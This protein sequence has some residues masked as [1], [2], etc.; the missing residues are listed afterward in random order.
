MTKATNGT[1]SVNNKRD[2][3][4]KYTASRIVRGKTVEAEVTRLSD[5]FSVS[6]RGGDKPHI[7]AVAVIDPEGQFTSTEFTGHREGIVCHQW[8]QAFQENGLKPAVICA[9][10]HYDGL[11]QAGISAV[12][13]ASGEILN[14]ILA[15]LR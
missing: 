5:S 9:G 14:E 1:A 2:L 7:G 11:D 6:V 3:I 4:E 13:T 8:A 10:I 15:Q 12:L